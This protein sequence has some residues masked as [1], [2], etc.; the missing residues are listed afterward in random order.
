V[1][2]WLN[3]FFQ[4]RFRV[5]DGL[6]IRFAKARTAGITRCCAGSLDAAQARFTE[7]GATRPPATMIASSGSH[8]DGMAR[9]RRRNPGGSRSRCRNG[10]D[11]G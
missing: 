10:K 9:I 5:I 8:L 4:M 3:T 2:T 11:T 7:H 6:T 1:T